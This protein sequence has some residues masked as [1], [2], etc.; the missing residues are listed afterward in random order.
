MAIF[1]QIIF[2]PINIIII[3]RGV[4]VRLV[5]I[6]LRHEQPA[7]RRTRTFSSVSNTDLAH[8][9]A[10]CARDCKLYSSEIDHRNIF[11][12][13]QNWELFQVILFAA[14]DI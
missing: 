9:I 12:H 7:K 11:L 5:L 3:N 8:M 6:Q 10:S 13:R 4:S 1:E 14:V 2:M